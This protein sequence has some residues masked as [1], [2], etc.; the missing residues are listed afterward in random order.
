MQIN[1]SNLKNAYNSMV[2]IMLADTGLTTNC[3]LVYGISKKDIC[4]NC[5][6]DSLTGKSSNRYK[7]DGPIYFDSNVICPY[8]YGIGYVGQETSEE[9]VYLAVIWDSKQ[10]I[11][12]NTDIKATDNYIQTI[13]SS[14]ILSKLESANY[15]LVNN[16]KFERQQGSSYSGLGDSNYIILTWRKII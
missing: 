13:C 11:N 14:K 8:C 9:N 3:T 1:F 4:P 12:F 6:F 15:I 10:W 5:I 7:N 16:Q 2:D